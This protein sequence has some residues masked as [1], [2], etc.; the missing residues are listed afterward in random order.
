MLRRAVWARGRQEARPHVR[1]VAKADSLR[2]GILHLRCVESTHVPVTAWHTS[3]RS[4]PLPRAVPF[5]LCEDSLRRPSSLLVALKFLRR[6]H[7]K[8]PLAFRQVIIPRVALMPFHYA[9][10]VLVKQP[11][12]S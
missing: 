7:A 9:A 3:C 4:V 8:T 5:I 11:V 2:L 10:A 12:T 1:G 6:G